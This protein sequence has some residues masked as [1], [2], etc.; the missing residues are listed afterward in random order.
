M[1]PISSSEYIG[2]RPIFFKTENLQM[3]SGKF[4]PPQNN[5]SVIF[6]LVTLL[7]ASFIRSEEHTLNSSHNA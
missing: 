3:A 4:C 1:G 6:A 5:I 2:Y 7:T